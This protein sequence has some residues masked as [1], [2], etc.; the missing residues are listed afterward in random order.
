[1]GAGE[2]KVEEERRMMMMTSPILNDTQDNHNT[3]ERGK[4]WK[5]RLLSF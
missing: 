2:R 3:L 1:M 5:K 4:E